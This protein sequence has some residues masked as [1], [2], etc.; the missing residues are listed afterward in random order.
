MTYTNDL[1][2]GTV[3]SLFNQLW[4]ALLIMLVMQA[5]VNAAA[6]FVIKDIRIE[7]LQRIAPGT[8][9]N[10]LPV[11]VG[12][13][14]DDYRSGEAARALFATGFFDDISLERD[15]DVLVIIVR[16][17]PTIGSISLSG[18]EDITSEDLI[19]GLKQVGFAEGRSFDRSDL[20]KLEQELRR[21]YNSLGKY[22][23]KLE[24]T[25]TEFPDNRVAVAIDI[26]EGAVAKIR[27]INIVGNTVY[28]EKE[29]LKL[30]QSG[31]SSWFSFFAK[32][33]QYSRQK[34]TADLESLRSHYLNNGYINFDIDSTQVSITPDKK[35]IYITVNISE[36]ELFTISEV[37]VA[38]DLILQEDELPHVISV[39]AGDIFS[40]RQ[41]T[42][43]SNA[44]SERLGNEGYAFVNVNA[45]PDIDN[46]TNSVKVTF[47]ID[48]GKRAYVRRIDF[49]GN[50]RTRDEVLRREMRQ[51]ER[52]WVS[53]KQVERG[54][55]RLQRLGFFEQVNVETP[56][57]PGTTDQV[58]VEYSVTEAPS[59][60]LSL[61][62]GFSQSGGFQLR[63]SVVQNN[64]LGSGKRVSFSFNNSSI[65]RRF[66]LGYTDP[67]YT[68]DGVSRNLNAFYHETD[69][70]D[71]NIASFDRTVL[72]SSI[73]FGIPITEYNTF[74]TALSYENTQVD[75]DSGAGTQIARFI[76]DN[77]DKFHILRWTNSLSFDTRNK[78]IL[79]D[80]GALHRLSAETA[81]PMLGNSLEFYKL[82]YKVQW[83]HGLFDDY[84]LSLKGDA[85][86][87]DSYGSGDLPFFENFYAGGPR[88][89][90]GYEENTLGPKDSDGDPLGG[91]IKLVGS[92]ELILPLPFLKDLKSIRVSAFL[93]GGNVYG[94]EEG[95]DIG[96]LRYSTG[97]GVIWVS[98]FGLVSASIAQPLAD[99][100]G[101]QLQQFQFNFGTSF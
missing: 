60:N 45:I 3:R 67:Y 38:G 8:V 61:G 26:S 52:S 66:G 54:R 55:V 21:Q 84:I 10:Y 65:N 1:M 34:L 81:L 31:T 23:V 40:R 57:V 53:T 101:D 78:T 33:D 46:D 63:T 50:T 16:E 87:G 42:D 70:T 80:T 39:R 11:K 37:R 56:T 12:D 95:F 68:I 58:D 7:G 13:T 75:A 91:H 85:G 77:G 18:N 41:L 32:K 98:P 43:S 27:K 36:G 100:E 22:A 51:Q 99:K 59:G 15:G 25:V 30:F 82:G 48:P 88:S 49:R 86:Y 90:R 72:G 79:P 96:E 17:R 19:D 93:D 29:L 24:S 44:L 6:E 28:S 69:S 89:V 14:F 47:F 94:S 9:F 83:F 64:F 35:S 76:R 97:L 71:A 92:A 2:G 5:G 73:R 4:C 74:H 62:L 20:E